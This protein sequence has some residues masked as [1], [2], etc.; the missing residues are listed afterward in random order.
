MLRFK[1]Q[2]LP[3]VHLNRDKSSEFLT[4]FN[5]MESEDLKPK[6]I[7]YKTA[8]KTTET[9]TGLGGYLTLKMN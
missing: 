7:D 2:V 8:I 4:A 5:S 6:F 1:T 3:P 9:L